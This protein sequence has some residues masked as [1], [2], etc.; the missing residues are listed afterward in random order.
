[1]LDKFN[2]K[3]SYLRVSVTDKCNLRC[4]Y[5]MPE[6]GVKLL[7]HNDIISFEEIIEVVKAGSRKGIEKVRITGGE[8]LVRKGI[9]KLVEMIAKI[10]GIR[11]FSLTTNGILLEDFAQPLFDAGLKRINISLDTLEEEKFKTITRGGNLKSVLKG[12]EAAQK[13]GFNPLKINCVIEN[14]SNEKDAMMVAEFCEKNNFMVRFI[15]TMSL[16]KGVFSVVEGGTGGD[17]DSCNRLRLTADGKIKPCLFNDLEYD[18]RTLGVEKAIMLALENKPEYGTH[19]RSN[20]FYNIG[21]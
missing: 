1:M 16:E 12:I 19:N 11:D 9:V 15:H 6:D 7:T 20:K 2:R 21:G 17:C 5:C 8:P 14:S 3:I 18:I 10:D 4:V 13:V